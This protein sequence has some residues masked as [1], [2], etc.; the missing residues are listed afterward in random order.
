MANGAPVMIWMAGPDK[1]P[2]YFNQTW[3]DFTGRPLEEELRVGLE[4]VTHPDDFERCRAIYVAAFDARQPFTK[5]CRLRRWDGQYRWLFDTGV[6]RFLANGVFAGYVGSCVDITDHKLAQEALSTVHRRL[7]QA[8]E[9]ERAR[10]ARELHDDISQ[11]LVMLGVQLDG[12]KESL[13]SAAEL[14]TNLDAARGQV[15][16]LGRDIQALAY[17]LHSAKLEHLGLA[18]AA[19]SFCREFADREQADVVFRSENVPADLPSEHALCLY[20][21][22]QEALQNAIR[23]SGSRSFHVSLRRGAHAIDLAV[24]DAGI[25]FDAERAWGRGLGLTSM[26]E[27]LAAVGGEFIIESTPGRGTTIRARVPV[28][29]Y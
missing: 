3:L 7:I 5:E 9:E 23:H 6:P 2:S 8:Q 11:R 19:S 20:R 13:D 29:V 25:G 26:K 16:D 22:M 27:R 10:I 12:A 24:H 17:R 18:P 14:A 1:R 21:I 28:G 4:T 15:A